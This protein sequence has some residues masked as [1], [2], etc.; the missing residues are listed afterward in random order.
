MLALWMLYGWKSG[1]CGITFFDDEFWILHAINLPL[2]LVLVLGFISKFWSST[3]SSMSIVLFLRENVL[4]FLLNQDSYPV[5]WVLAASE[6][7]YFNYCFLFNKW[8]FTSFGAP[9]P[10][11]IIQKDSPGGTLTEC[12][13]HLMYFPSLIDNSLVLYVFQCLKKASSYS[14]SSII[15][16]YGG[17]ISLTPVISLLRIFLLSIKLCIENFSSA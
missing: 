7:S 15:A 5:L 6:V 11:I 12:D 14:A 1:F 16:V 13:V 9:L 10:S 2:L 3:Y 8:L 4:S 17:R